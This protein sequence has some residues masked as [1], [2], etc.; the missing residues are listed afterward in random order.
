[1]ASMIEVQPSYVQYPKTEYIGH[2][3]RGGY[4]PIRIG[5]VIHNR[6]RVI[7]KLGYGAYS[8][9]WLVKDLL[10]GKY[11]SLKITA[12][13]HS[14]GKVA[15]EVQVIRYLRQK[16]ESVVWVSYCTNIKFPARD[17]PDTRAQNIIYLFILIHLESM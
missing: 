16:Q 2:Y 5:D 15:S 17:K 7:N 8:T 11:T 9:V 12:A 10:S 3:R 1:M 4:H 6:Y 14:K 13:E